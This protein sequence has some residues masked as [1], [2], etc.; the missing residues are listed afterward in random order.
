MLLMICP[1]QKKREDLTNGREFYVSC[2]SV[3]TI[4]NLVQLKEDFPRP[5]NLA[6]KPHFEQSEI[7]QR[8]LLSYFTK[9][10]QEE[11]NP[12][13]FQ[14]KFLKYIQT[15]QPFHPHSIQDCILCKL[16]CL[17]LILQHTSFVVNLIQGFV[18]FQLVPQMKNTVS[19]KR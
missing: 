1:G 10:K 6:K 4:N 19:S 12:K 18:R 2:C 5:P 16:L 15:L 11:E 8:Q 7:I 9:K 14:K 3:F 13:P 17:A